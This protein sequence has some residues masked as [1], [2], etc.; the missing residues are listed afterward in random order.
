MEFNTIKKQKSLRVISGVIFVAVFFGL[1]S[2]LYIDATHTEAVPPRLN[3]LQAVK[4]SPPTELIIP[5]INVRAKVEEV[6][7]TATGDMETPTFAAEVAWY[8]YGAMPGENGST[9]LAGHLDGADA[10][11]AVFAELKTLSVGDDVYVL[12]E[13]GRKLHY[14]VVD[15]KFYKS[16]VTDT[17]E[18]FGP[19]DASYL[20]LIT[21]TGKWV[22][23]AQ[24]YTERLVI[25]TKLQT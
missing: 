12:N 20:N 13:Q 16:G 24:N 17:K 18:I 22:E 25:F 8:K 14:K 4:A 1:C 9:V 23:K 6:G 7:V 11:P 5:K 3:I 21:C 2:I 19:R 15:K 10:K